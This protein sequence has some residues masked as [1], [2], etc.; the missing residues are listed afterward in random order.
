MSHFRQGRGWLVLVPA[1][2]FIFSAAGQNTPNSPKDPVP[3]AVV[4]LPPPMPSAPCPVDYFRRLLAMSPQQ[5]QAALSHKPAKV[6]ER[7]L[8]K[9]NEYAALAPDDRELR[10]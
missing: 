10:L 6:R 5:L 9:V 8:A 2:L 1:V 4:L 3:P 7:I